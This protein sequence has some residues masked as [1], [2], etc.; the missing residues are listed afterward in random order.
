MNTDS[1]SQGYPG[2]CT[3]SIYKQS[4]LNYIYSIE[5]TKICNVNKNSL[6]LKNLLSYNLRRRLKLIK[7]GQMKSSGMQGE[8]GRGCVRLLEVGRDC[9]RP[10]YVVSGG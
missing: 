7:R 8:I 10:W 6:R 1:F 9:F 2:L 3:Q 4:I 5:S